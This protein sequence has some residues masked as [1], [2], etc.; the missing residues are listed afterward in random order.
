MS[1][2]P[3][4]IAKIRRMKSQMT[5]QE[6]TRQVRGKTLEILAAAP[7]AWLTFAPAGTSNHILWHAGH[8]LW[9]QD[10][11]CIELLTGH[12]ELPDGWSD[13]FGMRCRPV[14]Q[15]TQWPSRDELLGM[16]AP[17]SPRS[18]IA[19][20]RGGILRPRS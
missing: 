6:L 8:A 7:P 15:T 10:V 16:K 12:S 3:V 20:S 19:I 18:R 4:S 17:H 13:T 11:L 5:L 14:K 2:T 1:T 9:L